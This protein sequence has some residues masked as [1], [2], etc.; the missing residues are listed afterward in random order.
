MTKRLRQL[1]PRDIR[2]LVDFLPRLYSDGTP[3]PV[4]PWFTET[5]DGALTMPWPEYNET[6]ERFFDLIV[7]QGCW[8]VRSYAP[9]ETEKLLMNEVA[10]RKAAIPEIQRMLT[11]V[12]RGEPPRWFMS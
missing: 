1:T 4:V 7:D 2:A 6:V 8:M 10:V 9:E 11:L 3:P 12:V 5:A